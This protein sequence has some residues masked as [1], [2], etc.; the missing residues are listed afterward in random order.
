MTRIPDEATR[1][2]LLRQLRQT[3]LEMRQ[4]TL[5]LDEVIAALEKHNREQEWQRLQRRRA[6][7]DARE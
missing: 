3:Q 1:K 5:M 7:L 2:R 4:A 6:F